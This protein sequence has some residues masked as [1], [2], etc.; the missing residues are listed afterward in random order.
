MSRN[1]LMLA[2]SRGINRD[3][4]AYRRLK[5]MLD[6]QFAAAMYHDA[7]RLA[8]AGQAVEQLAGE[9]ELRRQERVDLVRQLFDGDSQARME[10]VFALLPEAPARM[11]RSWWSE[12]ETLV[13]DCKGMNERLCH[14]LTDQQEIMQRLLG[15][16]ED[17]Y[18]PA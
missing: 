8:A 9:I 2:L 1:D 17:I 11:F 12:L 14:L 13:R 5:E 15:D 4:I 3:L 18:V 6:A 16:N 10:Q 7:P